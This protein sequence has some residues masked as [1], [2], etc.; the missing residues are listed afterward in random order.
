M[1]AAGIR[2]NR[3]GFLALGA[4][5]VTTC[6]LPAVVGAAPAVHAMAG[7]AFGT[8]WSITLPRSSDL[9]RL[10]EPIGNLLDRIDRR[11]SPWREESEISRFNRSA[12]GPHPVAAETAFVASAAVALSAATRGAF[13]PTVGPLVARWGFGPISGNEVPEWGGVAVQGDTISKQRDDLT[14]DLCGI[15]KGYALDRIV[16]LLLDAGERNFLV[17]LGGELAA[18]GRH[19][20]GR[21]W[22]AGV[23]DP[24]AGQAGI[25]AVLN[26]TDRAVATSGSRA[27][28]YALGG[29][30]YSHI[31]DPH[32]R[33]PVEG[34]LASVSVIDEDAMT[35]DGWATALMAAGGRRGP[36]VARENG[37]SALFLT[38]NGNELD[39]I[40]TGSFRDYL[41]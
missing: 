10:R 39:R 36:A 5:T 27:N 31:I 17:D 34:G 2:I 23:E 20:S 38:R 9:E 6:M 22:R 29:R 37:I 24:R 12:S 16:S 11:M 26:L 28:G 13:D 41:V 3:R 18:R 19:P 14:L 21:P 32:T 40:L 33:E 7:R 4:G 1:C 25:H 30:R 15:A 35:A 8:R